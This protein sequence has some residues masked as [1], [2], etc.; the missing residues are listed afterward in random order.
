MG[1]YV[2]FL[3]VSLSLPSMSFRGKVHEFHFHFQFSG[4]FLAKV[5]T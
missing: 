1:T 4:V 2:E 3:R 5:L